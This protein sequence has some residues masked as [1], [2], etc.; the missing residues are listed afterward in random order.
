MKK[1][2]NFCITKQMLVG[3]GFY[4]IKY[5]KILKFKHSIISNWLNKC[6]NLYVIEPS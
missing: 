4:F 6:K 2:N 5:E 1:Y 3:F